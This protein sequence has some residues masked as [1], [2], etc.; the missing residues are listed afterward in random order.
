MS[1]S[2]LQAVNFPKT[3]KLEEMIDFLIKHNL[4]PLKKIDVRQ[5]NYYRV[6]ITNPKKY[7][8]FSTKVLPDGIHLIIGYY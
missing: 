3:Y 8:S 2:E 5:L 4:K 1:N 6:R 7:R